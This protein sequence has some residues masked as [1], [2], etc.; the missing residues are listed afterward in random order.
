V[1]RQ[2][3]SWEED[4]QR[5][6]F[7]QKW[8]ESTYT[9]INLDGEMVGVLVLEEHDDCVFISEIQIAPDQQGRGLGTNV[10]SSVIDDAFKKGLPVRL[11]VLLLSNAKRLYERLGF[12]ET[13][14]TETHFLMERSAE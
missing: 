3:G 4:F 10:I 7:E 2:F 9:K 11:R 6:H 14:E 5:G 13:G 1:E 8:S 12:V